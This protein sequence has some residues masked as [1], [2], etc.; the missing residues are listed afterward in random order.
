MIT[1]I[2]SGINYKKK[3]L[4]KMLDLIMVGEVKKIVILYKDRLI[5]FRYELIEY[6]CEV[7]QTEI[8]IIDNI[9]N[10]ARRVCRGLS[11]DNN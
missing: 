7:N 11:S 6:I 9:K 5:G 8:E 2:G 1:D 10:R 4:L 3:G